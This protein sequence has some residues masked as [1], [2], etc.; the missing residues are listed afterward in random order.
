MKLTGL[1]V[2]LVALCLLPGCGT[3]GKNSI[4]TV[5]L[6]RGLDSGSYSGPG[7]N[8]RVINCFMASVD[9]NNRGG[10]CSR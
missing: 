8:E 1:A 10:P 2:I 7:L 4:Q 9:T 5:N 3:T 6:I